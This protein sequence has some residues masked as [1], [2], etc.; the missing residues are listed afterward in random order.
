ML[1]RKRN[2]TFNILFLIS[3]RSSLFPFAEPTDEFHH[4]LEKCRFLQLQHPK[5]HQEQHL[6]RLVKSCVA[7]EIFPTILLKV[8]SEQIHQRAAPIT[9]R[10]TTHPTIM[11]NFAPNDMKGVSLYSLSVIKLLFQPVKYNKMILLRIRKNHNPLSI[12]SFS[13]F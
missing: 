6:F 10:G 13:V 4:R 11:R 2:R 9:M 12:C 3:L 8:L 7:L 5:N 1:A